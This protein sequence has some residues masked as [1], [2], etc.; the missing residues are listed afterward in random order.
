MRVRAAFVCMYSYSYSGPER[1]R[2][3]AGKEDQGAP[4]D[5]KP[6]RE[7]H[8]E[9][10]AEDRAFLAEAHRPSEDEILARTIQNEF[11]RGFR[12]FKD[13]RN[14]ITGFGSARFPETHEYYRLAQEMGRR[15]ARAGFTVMT[16]G[17]P[18]IMEALNRGAREGGG[19]SLGCNIE[20]PEEQEPNPYLDEWIECKYFFAR[21]VMLVK[22]SSG[23]VLFPGGFGTMDEMFE[24]LTLIQ[25]GKIRNFP[26]VVMG[27]GYWRHLRPFVMDTM[28]QAGTIS[29]EDL[30]LFYATDD[31]EEAMRHIVGKIKKS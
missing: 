3:T 6:A 19:R 28:V 7:E 23:F 21:K 14:C 15:L 12:F 2:R 24:T 13:T 18:G 30:D 1:R 20:L 27:S 26:V 31:P 4:V 29:S 10:G 11:L 8:S 5:E 25:T 16:G 9:R 22:Y 17:G